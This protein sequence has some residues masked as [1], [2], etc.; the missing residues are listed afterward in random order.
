MNEQN[1][2]ENNQV[3]EQK[4]DENN[5]VN[6][7]KPDENNQVNEQKPDE[8]NQANEQNPDENNQVNEQNPDE[9]NQANEQKPDENN[10]ANEQNPDENKE[11]T[12]T[13]LIDDIIWDE[14]LSS[15]YSCELYK[16]CL[17]MNNEYNVLY[18]IEWYVDEK[19][20]NEEYVFENDTLLYG[21]IVTKY[22]LSYKDKN[23]LYVIY[24]QYD[25]VTI[26]N[27]Y[28]KKMINTEIYPV[29]ELVDLKID[30]LSNYTT[31][32]LPDKESIENI[33]YSS[34]K[35]Y[36]GETVEITKITLYADSLE[37]VIS[38]KSFANSSYIK[39]IEIIGDIDEICLNAFFNLPNLEKVVIRGSVKNINETYFYNCENIVLEILE[40]MD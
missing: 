3:N 17:D 13:Y 27:K 2:D 11:Y 24:S 8:N 15:E 1:L 22:A 19:Q 34:S 40:I 4:P 5:Q 36:R 39:E 23:F 31:E 10:Q 30:K 20:I 37:N 38:E 7:Q 14:I 33:L 32:M 28:Y 29:I 21:K 9:N 12:I 6:E 25:T 35:Y 26:P 18:E 16:Y